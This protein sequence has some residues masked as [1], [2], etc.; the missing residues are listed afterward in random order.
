MLNLRN[1][2]KTT[3][4]S[5]A[6]NLIYTRVLPIF[7]ML[8]GLALM[9][10]IF[11][12]SMG[13]GDGL[14]IGGFFFQSFHLAAFYLPLYFITVGLLVYYNEMTYR[15]LHILNWSFIPFLTLAL[16]LKT[17]FS[18]H[19]SVLEEFLLYLF[20]EPGATV[21]MLALFALELVILA[22]F[23]VVA[24]P[25]GDEEDL[26]YYE[27]T[28]QQ[29]KAQD[30][31]S[32][33]QQIADPNGQTPDVTD[34]LRHYL[35]ELDEN[36]PDQ[37]AQ[38]LPITPE[39]IQ[40]SPL[41]PDSVQIP[42]TDVAPP[43]AQTPAPVAMAAPPQAAIQAETP[44]P[45]PVEETPDTP[46][47]E[48]SQEEAAGLI[49]AQ[50]PVLHDA[51]HGNPQDL[52][53][54]LSY[55][56]LLSDAEQAA[57]SEVAD[58]I[59]ENSQEEQKMASIL[60]H[61]N[62]ELDYILSG[63][64]YNR[65]FKAMD[66]SYRVPALED[67]SQMVA[68]LPTSVHHNVAMAPEEYRHSG[69]I[70]EPEETLGKQGDYDY[71]TQH[72]LQREPFTSLFNDLVEADGVRTHADAHAAGLFHS[73]YKDLTNYHVPAESLLAE[74]KTSTYWE[75]DDETK[76]SAGI[77]EDTLKEFNIQAQVTGIQKGPV[78]TMFELLPAPGVKLS[79]I[80]AL[81]D[82]IAFRLAAS[83]VRIVA[84]IP[85]KQAV[86]IEVPNK[87]RSLVSFK[88]MVAQD[89]LHDPGDYL[90]IVL[91]KDIGGNPQVVDLAKMPHL[92]I[93]GSTGS[94]K[95]VCVN[96][97]ICSFLFS[98]S[99]HDVRMILIDPK[100]VELKPYNDIP[101]LLT[102]VITEPLKALQAMHW[103]VGEMERRYSLL[104]S[105]GVRNIRSYN[106]K[107]SE[108]DLAAEKLPYLVIVIDEFAD[109]MAT[110]GK[111]LEGLIARL[112]AKSRAAGI[113][114][115]IATQ[116][117]SVDVITGLIKANFP[118]R[119][120]FMVA[121]KTDSRIILDTGGAEQLL[122]KGD[123]LFV[124]SWHPFPIRVQG[125]YL[126]EEEVEHVASYVKSLAKPHYI[127][128]EIFPDENEDYN[129]LDEDFDDDP[130]FE[131]AVEIVV[132]SNKATA[133][134]LQRRLKVGYNRAA[135]LIDVMEKRGIIG[136]A[137]G[138]KPRDILQSHL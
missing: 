84:P 57:L 64:E 75:I 89:A 118:S 34:Q 2:K 112:A 21:I 24:A 43:L 39:S 18:V 29:Y 96:G 15:L 59:A 124:S 16:A 73:P 46:Q 95:S 62:R 11:S 85:D 5:H 53:P 88:E 69:R 101:H 71:E 77:L 126:S 3:Q 47:A 128:D 111:E 132:E 32:P 91:G 106:K 94:G 93:A 35:D 79:R 78:I 100:V 6:Q 17:A 105:L 131:K 42:T 92:L 119:I 120:A 20:P 68:P 49:E 81:S 19:P 110:C 97:I 83:R 108:L 25:T 82:N 10:L 87:E 60:E 127:D 44:P 130:L 121:S 14:H 26:I 125:A 52:P 115:I 7:F 36:S 12:A 63:E 67:R 70:D 117:P 137:N 103:A 22:R 1:K 136:P 80:E 30:D 65:P 74:Y 56:P 31:Y 133:S 104:D 23:W 9:F 134:Y 8:F 129:D 40:E 113:H 4:K 116:R 66:T 109:L 50:P 122:G 54:H 107:V 27:K 98:R 138:S 33:Q 102:S 38:S 114:L 61:A 48:I 37:I 28:Q 86:G 90:P 123:L 55:K 41:S 45:A 51:L 135:R 58:L 76:R 72:R 99:P 13:M